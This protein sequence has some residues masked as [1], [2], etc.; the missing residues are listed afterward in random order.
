MPIWPLESLINSLLEPPRKIREN[1]LLFL[2]CLQVLFLFWW[3]IIKLEDGH[4]LLTYLNTKIYTWGILKTRFV[5]ISPF[6][7]ISCLLVYLVNCSS[8]TEQKL[9]QFTSEETIILYKL[10]KC[11][12]F[13]IKLHHIIPVPKSWKFKSFWLL[14]FCSYIVHRRL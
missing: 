9:S 8:G 7:K 6:F 1:S 12:V 14:Y 13:C 3:N 11:L 4:P 10:F 2:W 5:G